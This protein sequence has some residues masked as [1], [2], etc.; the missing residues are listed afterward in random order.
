M[1]HD[2]AERS[3]RYSPELAALA[4]RRAARLQVEA[5]EREPASG[6][7]RGAGPA[8][9]HLDGYA[10]EDLVQA[11]REVGIEGQ[12][13][14][15]ALAELQDRDR[16]AALV[17]EDPSEERLAQRWLGTRNRALSVTQVIEGTPAEVW[18]LLGAVFEDS[19]AGLELRRVT[20]DM[21]HGGMAHFAMM[22]LKHM[23]GERGTYTPLCYHMEQLELRE[24]D[25]E[26]T[27]LGTSTRVT[28]HAD[29]R[30][31]ARINLRW[32]RRISAGLGVMMG[33]AGILGGAAL[34]ALGV[35]GF[36][37]AGLVG[38]AGLALSLWRWSYPRAVR[39]LREDLVA[40]LERIEG[41][42]LRETGHRMPAPLPA[43]PPATSAPH[44][45]RAPSA[46]RM[47]LQPTAAG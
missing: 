42:R 43:L 11:A 28:V 12:H 46:E 30:P 38:G 25:V 1:T 14:T 23:M 7:E 4:L 33:G 21:A 8:Q 16:N 5:Q 18:R 37:A 22:P 39:K 2:S 32:A 27:D 35:L 45:D 10:H 13:L 34:G 17:L 20:G 26:L 31:G 24:L 29:L 41:R 47:S 40:M 36:G 6:S 44:G 19:R 9:D 3:R 15:V